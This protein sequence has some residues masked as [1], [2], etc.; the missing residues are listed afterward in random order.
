M[1][2]YQGWSSQN[3][4]QNSKKGRPWSDCFLRSSLDRHC[5]SR[6][7][8]HATSVWNFR[9]STVVFFANCTHVSTVRNRQIS[10]LMG[11]GIND[12]SINSSWNVFRTDFSR[13]LF[14]TS[15]IEKLRLMKNIQEHLCQLFQTVSPSKMLAI[16]LCLDVLFGH[17]K[18][19]AN[20]PRARCQSRSYIALQKIS[21]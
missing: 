4:C 12:K 17:F 13:Y 7:F 20:K 6:P 3:A 16:H 18:Q 14:T 8:C 1:F 9:T 10:Q 5:L 11:F 15:F 2:C 21:S 19:S